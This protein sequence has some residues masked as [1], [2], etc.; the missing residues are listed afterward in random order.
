MANV[1]NNEGIRSVTHFFALILLLFIDTSSLS[2][3]HEGADWVIYS[4]NPG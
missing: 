4:H 3:S 2:L 1:Q